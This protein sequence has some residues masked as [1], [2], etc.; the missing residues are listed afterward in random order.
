MDRVS[1][2]FGERGE[3]SDERGKA[4]ERG[5]E[6]WGRV[7]G[8]YDSSVHNYSHLSHHSKPL[9]PFHLTEETERSENTC[10]V[11][12]LHHGWL[13]RLS[14]EESVSTHFRFPPLISKPCYETVSRKKPLLFYFEA[15][16]HSAKLTCNRASDG[17]SF[18]TIK[19]FWV[20]KLN[21]HN[22]G[23]KDEK[24]TIAAMIS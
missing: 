3:R 8:G 6:E 5:R 16:T 24:K 4:V 9:S 12:A 7:H 19:F 18:S 22:R 10:F 21:S 23:E 13:S 11:A 15:L 17:W 2:R 14:A 1:G 20:L